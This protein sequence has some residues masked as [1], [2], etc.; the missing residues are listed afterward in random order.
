MKEYV[1]ILRVDSPGP[2][3]WFVRL[4]P[5]ANTVFRMLRPLYPDGIKACSIQS[6]LTPA[7]PAKTAWMEQARLAEQDT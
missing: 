6:A 1:Y 7:E 3:R 4:A 2:T 5:D